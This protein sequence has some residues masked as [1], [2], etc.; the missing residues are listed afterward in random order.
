MSLFGLFERRS[1]INNPAVPLTD[2]SLLSWLS[3]PPG[4]AGITV[5][6]HTAMGLS[7]VYRAASL[8][9]SVAAALPLHTYVDGTKDRV[10]TS[11][12]VDPHPDMSA[13]ELWR[14]TYLHRVLWGNAFLLKERDGVNR[15]KSLIPVPPSRV[16]V[17]R[18]PRTERV[19]SGKRF[20]YEDDWG[21]V[22]NLDSF[23]MLHIPGLGYDG[24]QGY[25]PIQLARQGLGM[26]L[27]AE[28]HGAKLFGSGN[29]L[30]GLLKTEQ[31]LDQQQV[32]AIKARWQTMMQGPDH[33]HEVAVLGSGAEFQS[34]QM[35]ND[36]A[37]FLESRRFQ[38]SEISR[39][40]GVPPFLMMETEKSTSW[41]TGLEQQAIGW[42][43]FDL[44]PQWLAP[45]EQRITK[46]ILPAGRYSKYVV[47]GL[48]RGDSQARA[49]FY[50]T[51]REVGAFSAND[52]LELEDRPPVADGDGRL[53]PLNFVPLGTEP[54][55]DE[56]EEDDEGTGD[57]TD[58]PAE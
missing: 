14:I 6:E 40:F 19:P 18:V 21:S 33:A 36:D 41:G 11:L 1:P 9:A 52:I 31:K 58:E 4:D 53:Q 39:L 57:G 22:R 2:S 34:L 16:T 17:E 42:V 50:R 45:T 56:P 54:V 46:E 24:Y 3:G 43:K 48:L 26:A 23:Q 13:Y 15:I 10:S 32:D 7:A 55:V 5:N 20:R 47:E 12:L 30:S 27:A 35:P 49:E 8:I 28:R 44:H 51:M 37:Q 29:M 25:S 38:V